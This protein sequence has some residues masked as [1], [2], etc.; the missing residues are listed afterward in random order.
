MS[1]KLYIINGP[2]L[3]LLGTREPEKY[4]NISLDEINKLCSE[5]CNNYNL[6]LSFF[7]SISHFLKSISV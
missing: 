4:G 5:K 1:K 3:N 7:Q 2:N 6:D